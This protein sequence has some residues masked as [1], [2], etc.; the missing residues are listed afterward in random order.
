MHL[1][2][3]KRNSNIEFLSLKTILWLSLAI[4]V[5]FQLIF[6]LSMFF[7]ETFFVTEAH[8]P[9]HHFDIG[10]TLMFTALNFVLV[11]L[12]FLYNRRIMRIEFRKKY[13]ELLFVIIGSVLIASALSI[14]MSWMPT[15]FDDPNRSHRPDFLYRIIRDGLVRDLSLMVIVIMAA[16]LT[17][18]LFERKKIAVENEMLRTENIQSRFEALKSQMDPHFLFNS[19]NTLQS[20][21]ETDKEK[22]EDFIQQ[23]SFVLR[24]TLQNKEVISLSEEL[25]CVQ[26]YCSMMQIRY[27]D[28]LK[29]DFRIR[30]DYE[31]YNVLPL[32]L[33]GLIENAIK[34]NVISAKQPLTVT[35]STDEECRL[36]VSN[37]IQPK[38]MDEA[39]NGI[40]LANLSERYRLMWNEEVKIFDDGKVFEV[41]LPLKG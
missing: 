17:R 18:S 8:G 3:N 5:G 11:F 32:A 41:T 29:F 10:R 33:Q 28:N 1:D 20:L 21:I 15:L 6:N 27:G 4:S 36:K 24:Y 9:R 40:G 19:M 7:G 14:C 2:M 34:H 25:K 13:N 12:V 16:Q 22:A 30:P 35:V 26:A 31:S 38:I 39:G 23:L 37:F